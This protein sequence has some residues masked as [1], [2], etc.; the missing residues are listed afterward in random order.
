VQQ[1]NETLRKTKETGPSRQKNKVK[2]RTGKTKIDRIKPILPVFIF[3]IS[4]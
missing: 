2:K 1:N 4:D 3:F